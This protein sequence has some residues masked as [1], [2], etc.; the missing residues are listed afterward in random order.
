MKPTCSRSLPLL[1][2]AT[3]LI[4]TGCIPTYTVPPITNHFSNYDNKEWAC[5]VTSAFSDCTAV[6]Y[7]FTENEKVAHKFTVLTF[8]KR[9]SRWFEWGW[10]TEGMSAGFYAAATPLLTRYVALDPFLHIG[11]GATVPPTGWAGYGARGQIRIPFETDYGNDR[12]I[13]LHGGWQSSNAGFVFGGDETT[14]IETTLLAVEI[15][16][17]EFRVRIGW[18]R[19]NQTWTDVDPD[20]GRSETDRWH[21]YTIGFSVGESGG[22]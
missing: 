7:P 11:L 8:G 17:P 6:F 10:T 3:A 16:S 9:E 13:E 20:Y 5:T 12:L 14:D 19:V 18:T 15:G 1:L 4:S 2:L 21:F 22:Y